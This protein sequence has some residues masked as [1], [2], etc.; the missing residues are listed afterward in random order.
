MR[1]LDEETPWTEAPELGMLARIFT[2]DTFN[3]P[4][5]QAG[6][7][8]TPY[9]SVVLARYQ[10]TKLRHFHHL[11]AQFMALDEAAG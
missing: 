10:E 6:L 11:L 4:N 5:V 2:Q 1:L 3:L 8:A 7:M 9:E